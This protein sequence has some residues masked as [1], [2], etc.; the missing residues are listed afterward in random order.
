MANPARPSFDEVIA[1]AWGDAVSDTVVRRYPTTAA[2]DTDLAGFATAALRGQVCWLDFPAGLTYH[3]GAQ[4]VGV[5]R[6]VDRV[7]VASATTTITAPAGTYPAGCAWRVKF[8]GWVNPTGAAGVASVRIGRTSPS[9]VT[10]A[11]MAV[12]MPGGVGWPVPCSFEGI[13]TGAIALTNPVW[14]VAVVAGA[15]TPQGNLELSYLGP[16]PP[17]AIS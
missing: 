13:D 14:S 16:I 10:L 7:S 8:L 9:A 5:E 2:R 11:D 6:I 1:E 4:W 12:G 3:D 15:A 17:A